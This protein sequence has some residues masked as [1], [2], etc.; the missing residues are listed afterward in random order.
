MRPVER[1]VTVCRIFL[2]DG[3]TVVF[4]VM[5]DARDWERAEIAAYTLASGD[6]RILLEGGTDGRYVSPGLLVFAQEGKLLAVRL[7]PGTLA[8]EG[9]AVPVLEGVT[10]SIHAPGA[11]SRT[12]TANLDINEAGTLAYLAGSVI[13]EQLKK[14]VLVDRQGEVEP[15]EIE[16]KQYISARMAPNGGTVLLATNYGKTRDVWTY[17]LERGSLTRQTFDGGHNWAVWG[18]GPDEFT[19]GRQQGGRWLALAKGVG[20]GPGQMRELASGELRGLGSAVSSWSP[21]GEYLA[22]LLDGDETSWDIWTLSREGTLEP[23]LN[24]PLGEAFPEISP[25][26][27]W[28]AYSM[29]DEAGRTDVFV[30]PFPGSGPALQVSTGGEAYQ[31]AWS[32]DGQEL[33]YRA[34]NAF[35]AVG[36]ETTDDRIQTTRPELLFRGE[37]AEVGPVRS[38]DV[39]PDGRLLLIQNPDPKAFAAVLTAIF[40]KQVQVV[41]NWAAELER[42]LGGTP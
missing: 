11:M 42:K 34:G 12:G 22:L 28:I 25:D 36:V 15:L 26:G 13:P 23:F 39:T 18:P 4:T 37:Y 35:Y 6:K 10:H 3:R 9:A 21:D 7:E 14:V 41:Q 24:S 2:P 8:V 29:G 1:R 32:R 27:R 38:W 16:A 33:V 30:R 5:R 19:V 31:S 20:S 40:P 17:D